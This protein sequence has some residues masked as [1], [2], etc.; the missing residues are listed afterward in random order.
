[1][2][3]LRSRLNEFALVYSE[4]EVDLLSKKIF[5]VICY[6]PIAKPF[7]GLVYLR[8]TI[9]YY[10]TT[11]KYIRVCF[12]LIDRVL[13]KT[14]DDMFLCKYKPLRGLINN[15]VIRVATHLFSTLLNSQSNTLIL[16]SSSLRISMFN[17]VNRLRKTGRLPTSSYRSTECL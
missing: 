10:K 2:Q 9:R 12:V 14:T 7:V 13:V 11:K 16:F 6:R 8:L 1:M 4:V 15:K 3:C 5:D 17:S